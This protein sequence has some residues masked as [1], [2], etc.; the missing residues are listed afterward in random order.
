L[1][2]RVCPGSTHDQQSRYWYETI[3]VP[4]TPPV[5]DRRSVFSSLTGVHAGLAKDAERES[6]TLAFLQWL[7]TDPEIYHLLLYG[8]EG[9]HWRWATLERDRVTLLPGSA[10]QPDFVD[11]LGNHTLAYAL[12]SHPA[13]L[14]ESV[15]QWNASAVVS[16]VLGFEFDSRPV[17]AEVAAVQGSLRELEAPVTQARQVDLDRVIEQ[18]IGLQE[19]AGLEAFRAELERQLE[20]WQAS[21]PTQ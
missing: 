3:D 19:R 6:R 17:A 16:P 21:R 15:R 1:G 8:V 7:H 9:R 18:I 2:H 11:Q 5:I 12:D 13:G 4:H 14:W 10:Y 20:E